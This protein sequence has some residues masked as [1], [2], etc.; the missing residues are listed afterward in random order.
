MNLSNLLGGG[1][2]SYY[3][4]TLITKAPFLSPISQ[5]LDIL[6]AYPKRHVAYGPPH[7]QMVQPG[8]P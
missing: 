2:V 1:G 4:Y 5:H 8:P 6:G 7:E 3:D